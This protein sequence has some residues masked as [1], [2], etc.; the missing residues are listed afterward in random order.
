MKQKEVCLQIASLSKRGISETK[1]SM[2]ANNFTMIN[3]ID[4]IIKQVRDSTDTWDE[5]SNSLRIKLTRRQETSARSLSRNAKINAEN[6]DF[7]TE[8][9]TNNLN[10]LRAVEVYLNLVK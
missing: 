4:Q 1:R 2:F 5:M 6:L 7:S 3:D 10:D 9:T 8:H